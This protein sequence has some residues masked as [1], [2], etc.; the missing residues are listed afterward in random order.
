MRTQRWM[1]IN[2]NGVTNIRKSKPNTSWDEVSILLDINLPDDLFKKPRLEAKITIPEEAA[3]SE[4]ITSEVIENVQ[5]AIKTATGL[6]FSINVIKEEDQDAKEEDGQE[7][8]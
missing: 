6:T 4:P 7:E 5:E 3:R 1:T 2:R 8:Q